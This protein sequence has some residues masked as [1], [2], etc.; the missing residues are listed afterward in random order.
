MKDEAPHDPSCLEFVV[1]VDEQPGS[2]FELMDDSRHES[3]H[4]FAASVQGR[5]LRIFRQRP[6][7]SQPPLKVKVAINWRD[8]REVPNPQYFTIRRKVPRAA[9]REDRRL[10]ALR[11]SGLD[12]G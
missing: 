5:R 4:P 2:L 8:P 6:Q 3:A 12:R 10:T 7:L 9:D 11:V 1:L